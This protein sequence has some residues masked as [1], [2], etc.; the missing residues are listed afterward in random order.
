[1]AVI[2]MK[3]RPMIAQ[4]KPALA[5]IYRRDRERD[6][7]WV[8]HPQLSDFE[9]DSANE[10]VFVAEIDGEIV[11]F[12]SLYRVMNFIHLLFVSPD[13]RHQGVGH[14][15]LEAMRQEATGMLTLKCVIKNEA[16]LQFY[17]QEGFSIRREDWLAFPANYTLQD[18]HYT[19]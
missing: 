8:A 11:G 17:A 16:A 5:E 13:Y 12:V 4:D 6:F 2:N 1:M 3:I 14:A 19:G 15:L 7:P 9:R 10:S 18:N